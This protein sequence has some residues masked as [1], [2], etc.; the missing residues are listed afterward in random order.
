MKRCLWGKYSGPN[1]TGLL[2]SHW[3]TE[4]FEAET[5]KVHWARLLFGIIS[6]LTVG[7]TWSQRGRER[8]LCCRAMVLVTLQKPWLGYLVMVCCFVFLP[9][10]G[11]ALPVAAFATAASAASAR[12]AAQLASCSPWLSTTASP[13][14]TPTSAGGLQ[15]LKTEFDQWRCFELQTIWSNELIY[16]F[17]NI[18]NNM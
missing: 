5:Y 16:A 4:P 17:F 1:W 9:R 3:L 8:M 11:S 10:S 14:S 12:A 2:F 13:M 15:H 7:E 6:E 18:R